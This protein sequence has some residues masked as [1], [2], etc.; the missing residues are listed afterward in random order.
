M[1]FQNRFAAGGV[2]T[3]GQDFT[4]RAAER[5]A[6]REALGT[7]RGH[8]LLA[9]PR[10]MGKTS[11]L[12][13]VKADCAR[14][15][16]L[17]VLFADLWAAST[18][19][20]VTTRLLR[21]ASEALGARWPDLPSLLARLQLSWTFDTTLGF[22]VPLPNV[23]LREAEPAAQAK[24]LADTLDAIEALAAKRRTRIGIVLDEF[25]EVE[26]L[27]G[28][29]GVMK[30]LRAAIQHHAWVTYVFSGSD[31]RA[32]ATLT[33]ARS[34]PLHN[35]ATRMELGPIEPAHFARWIEE[36][37][38]EM[39]F[40]PAAGTG[41][42]VIAAAGP[43]T[44]DV[45]TLAAALAD[46]CHDAAVRAPSPG[47]VEPAMERVVVARGPQYDREWG[48]LTP[49]QQNVL[50]ACAVTATGIT[51]RETLTRFGLGETS[52]TAK[53][54]RA[55]EATDI[56][57]REGRATW[58]FDDPFFRGWVLQRAVPDVGLRLPVTHDPGGR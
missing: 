15:D 23:G 28:A 57:V 16:K 30:Q 26:T 41:L 39:H 4:D 32:I 11:L 8:V 19:E 43:R 2:A 3:V 33:A 29:G 34:G 18:V 10:R 51:R 35:F 53:A 17:P 38:R 25:Q 47:A 22:P 44:R 6:L 55:L 37:F 21:A 7:P 48:A 52:R 56:L 27:G 20:D 24:R 36:T 50:R 14:R 46:L 12:L 45:R 5:R 31:R 40:R 49:H 58:H 42:A 54:L 13:A 1:V 9:G